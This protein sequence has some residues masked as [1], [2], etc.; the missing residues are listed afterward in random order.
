MMVSKSG[1]PV[2]YYIFG[3]FSISNEVRCQGGIKK[4][5]QSSELGVRRTNHTKRG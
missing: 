5:V 1:I 4:E 2:L 3:D